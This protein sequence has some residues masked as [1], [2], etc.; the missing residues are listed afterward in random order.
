MSAAA[1]SHQSVLLQ[2]TVAQLFIGAGVYVDGTFGRGG[3]SRLLLSRLS[4]DSLLIVADR[5][6][7]AIA[8]AA[9]LAA[10]DGRVEVIQTAFSQLAKVLAQRQLS[11]RLSGLLLD[12]GV[13]SPQLDDPARGFSFQ[14]D[15]P[16]DM[17]MDPQQGVSAAQWLQSIAEQEL[18]DVLYRF[19]DERFSRRIARAIVAAR[20]QAPITRTGQLAEIIKQAHPRWDHKKHPATRSFQ[21]IR[22]AVNGELDELQQMMEGALELLRPGGRLAIISFH[23]LEDRAV[24]QFIRSQANGPSLPPDLPVRDQDFVRTLKPIGKAIRPA[25]EEVARNPR[26]RSAVLRVAERLP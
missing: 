19:G 2:E 21:A 22:I 3:H 25:P 13:S 18:A 9:R 5:D 16:L 17:R 20:Q 26:A 11:G 12:L 23:S 10:T 7:L 1:L 6:P 8:E 14:L 15:G 24:K 4:A